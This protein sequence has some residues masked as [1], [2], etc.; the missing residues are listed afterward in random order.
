MVD[1]RFDQH[2]PNGVHSHN[3]IRADGGG[4]VDE[5]IAFVPKSKV[6]AVTLVTT[7]KYS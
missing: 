4:C 2:R 1:P 5:G 7:G 3:S 6:V